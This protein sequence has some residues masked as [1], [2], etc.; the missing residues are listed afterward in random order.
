MLFT[1]R[2][3]II[4]RPSTQGSVESLSLVSLVCNAGRHSIVNALACDRLPCSFTHPNDNLDLNGNLFLTRSHR[5]WVKRADSFFFSPSSTL[6]A[7]TPS[8]ACRSTIGRFFVVLFVA[9]SFR[10]ISRRDWTS[11]GREHLLTRWEMAPGDGRRNESQHLGTQHH[12]YFPPPPPRPYPPDQ[13]FGIRTFP[14]PSPIQQHSHPIPS[15]VQQNSLPFIPVQQHSSVPDPTF[16]Y[17]PF[18][19]YGPDYRAQAVPRPKRRKITTV[20][21]GVLIYRIT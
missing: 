21:V 17:P 16:Y 5:C 15:A 4:A 3:G 14:I 13:S 19:I 7:L 1:L 10:G 6:I 20:Q 12:H 18:P 11:S 9:A 2:I 8:P